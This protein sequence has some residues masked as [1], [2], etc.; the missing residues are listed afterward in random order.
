MSVVI[1]DYGCGNLGSFKNML[2]H[3]GIDQKQIRFDLPNRLDEITH[4]ILPGVGK[5]D[6]AMDHLKSRN[7]IDRLH[8]INDM[9]IPILG[10]CLG[11]QI[12]GQMSAEGKLEGLKWFDGQ[13]Y[14]FDLSKSHHRTV[15]MGWE[16]LDI[17]KNDLNLFD[18]A[19]QHKFYFMHSYYYQSSTPQ[20]H[21]AYSTH[22]EIKLV[23]A[24]HKE[25]KIGVQFH[26]EKSHR[27]GMNLFRNFLNLNQ[28]KAENQKLETN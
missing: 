5:F 27:F 9:K 22:N 26:P 2:I 1:L 6:T 13:C 11:M 10:I 17:V 16:Y 24:I 19:L 14:S 18:L 3:I 8:Q 15:H 4:L 23:A 25:N 28:I 7:L 12:M 21:L 20:E